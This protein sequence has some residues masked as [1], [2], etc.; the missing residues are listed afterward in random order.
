MFFPNR[1]RL[2]M[3]ARYTALML[4]ALT[5]AGCESMSVS[6]CK[7][8]DW[9]RVGWTD[10]S[11]GG[12]E[13]RIADYTEDCGK[14]GIVPNAQAYRQGWDAGIVQFCTAA[15]GWREG[16]QGHSG[17]ASVCQG[18]AGYP[19]F[20][21]YLEA[22]LQV[23]RTNERMQSNAQ[24]SN[25]LQQRLDASKNDDE[26]K[27]LREELRHIDREQFRLRNQLIQQQMLAP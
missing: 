20:A 9:H 5:L 27:N 15:N 24:E 2:S 1:S 4:A 6:E 14:A 17:K 16:T 26:R 23:Y 19:A 21:R 8:A 7:V 11:Q 13:R 25:R 3:P 10:G 12:S 18:Q 22:G